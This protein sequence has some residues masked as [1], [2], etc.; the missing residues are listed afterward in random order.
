MG[1]IDIILAVISIGFFIFV[2]ELVRRKHLREKYS[3]I[4]IMATGVLIVMSFARPLIDYVALKLNI[5]YPPSLIFMVGIF[6]LLL[7]NVALS[8]IVSHQT[9]RI[10]KLI[11]EQA[12]L[13]QRVRKLESDKNLNQKPVDSKK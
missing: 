6:F 11:Q 10:I 3:L 12:L 5:Y 2:I 8:V 9:T 7:L 1:I 4:W 13:E